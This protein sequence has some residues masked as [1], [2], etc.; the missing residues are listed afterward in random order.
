MIIAIE[1]QCVGFEHVKFNAAFLSTLALAYPDDE[2]RFYSEASHG[3]SVIETCNAHRAAA[4]RQCADLEWPAWSPLAWRKYSQE[5][6]LCS[7]I[8]NRA[9]SEEARLIVFCSVSSGIVLALKNLLPRCRFSKPVIAVPHSV[10]F[11]TKRRSRRFWNWPVQISAALRAQCPANLRLIALSRLIYVNMLSAFPQTLWAHLDHPLISSD[12][13]YPDRP[14][15]RA[16]RI[17]VFG[18]L[19]NRLNDFATLLRSVRKEAPDV[20]FVQVGHIRSPGC[21]EMDGLL[22]D[23]SVR[24]LS[25]SDY[26]TLASSVD[27]SIML[28]DP[29]HYRYAASA[30]LLECFEYQVPF[31]AVQ[32]ALAEQFLRDFGDIGEC[33]DSSS[34]LAR[35]IVSASRLFPLMRHKQQRERLYSARTAFQPSQLA[36]HLAAI[37]SDSEN[38]FA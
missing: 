36:S 9:A 6:A 22:T 5:S 19:R 21:R 3:T 30:T 29:L 4:V 37:I 10:L 28:A 38:S 7:Q 2:I 32:H 27:Y 1:P 34:D 14:Q 23:L 17:G 18:A 33:F 25:S 24:P 11:E 8:L 35:A 13:R 26:S 31:L 12:S 16:L 20:E 15:S